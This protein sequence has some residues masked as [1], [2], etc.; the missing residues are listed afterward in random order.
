MTFRMDGWM[1]GWVGGD[2]SQSSSSLLA[3]NVAVGR[4]VFALPRQLMSCTY[5]DDNDTD[6]VKHGDGPGSV[7]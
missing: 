3:A 4:M 2:N 7:C 1:D 5:H 6:C